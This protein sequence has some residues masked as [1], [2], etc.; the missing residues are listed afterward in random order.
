MHARFDRPMRV[1]IVPVP[2][3]HLEVIQDRTSP[4]A[5]RLREFDRGRRAEPSV[6]GHAPKLDRRAS[7]PVNG[8]IASGAVAYDLPIVPGIA[9][10]VHTEA[11]YLVLIAQWRAYRVRVQV[12]GRLE[13]GE[14]NDRSASYRLAR[15]A[16]PPLGVMSLA[17]LPQSVDRTIVLGGRHELLTG[18]R[19]DLRGLAN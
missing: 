1:R 19:L 4:T 8:P 15:Y 18:T 7:D 3:E 14:S 11:G 9:L 12:D 10:P 17:N 2:T 5:V 13:V 16:R 6:R